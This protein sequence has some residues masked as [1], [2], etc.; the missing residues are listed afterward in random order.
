MQKS[1]LTDGNLVSL[2][3]DW[4]SKSYGVLD[5]ELTADRAEALKY[6][7]GDPFGNEVEGRSAVVSRDVLDV[8]ESALPQLLKVF[9]S[10]DEIVRFE[11]RGQEDE[12]AAAQETAV[13][14]YVALEKND[15]FAIFYTWFKDALLSKNGYVKV[16]Y[17][18]GKDVK[19]E[20]YQG[21]TDEQLA[22]LLR[23]D[24]V[25]VIEHS[26]T[27][28]EADLVM[29]QEAIAQ[30]Q[31][32]EQI[33]AIQMEPTK[34][35]HDVKIEITETL[36]KIAI[37]NVAPEDILVGHDTRS[38]SL[39]DATF[40]QHRALMSRSEIDEQGWDVP[41]N[42]E[43][44]T[45]S[46][47]WE[48][49]NARDIYNENGSLIDDQYLVKDT[50]IRVDGELLRVV[51]IGNEIVYRK[52]AEVI[53][54]AAI[55]PH[56]MPHRHVGMSYA[57]LTKD[58]QLIKSTLI[59]GELDAMYL[60]NQPRF[61]ISERVN[62]NDMLV[63]RPNGVVRVEGDPGS[64]IMPLVSP[65]PSP[66]SFNLVEYLDVAKE[67][68]TGITA[69]NQGLDANSLNKTA[70]GVSQIMQAAQQRLDLVARTFANTGV[71]E[72]FILVHRMI[73]THY[74][75]PETIK[76]RGQWV[77]VD[78]REWAERKNMSVVVGLG[79]GNRDQQLTHLNNMIALQ[80]QALQ[81][82]LPMVTP[83]NIFNTARQIAI[84]AG[85]KQP[86]L[87]VT[88]P[89]QVPPKPPQEPPQLT[90]KKMELQADAQKF[91]AETVVRQEEAERS[92]SVEMQKAQ[93]Q[94]EIDQRQ[95]EQNA[96]LEQQ[97]S[98]NDMQLER[99][100]MAMQAELK[101]YEIDKKIE[102]DLFIAQLNADTTI[103]IGATR[104][105]E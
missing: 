31:N 6:Y 55:T 90:I 21:L 104:W 14:N 24:R 34:F 97:R 93:Y 37:C 71:K 9:V 63:S 35:L 75:K 66:I 85:F 38:V 81:A 54:F 50:Y 80:M 27:I 32:P 78:P 29:R 43:R 7:N 77:T 91:Q 2:I 48:E 103:R 61:A 74:T 64:S 10:G 46:H 84:N 82:G 68:R 69:Y 5:S 28:D 58:I 13:V 25:T 44:Y 65:G 105:Q 60:A 15:G 36:D 95:A 98:Q 79:T 8:I 92:A 94:A 39:S 26:Q 83:E 1:D 52:P 56:I 11:P 76:L 22:I 99:E 19:I 30:A 87:F 102:A 49:E 53:P 3:E 67:R 51:V 59:R 45:D 40:V 88:D 47:S 42:V 96:F 12:E 16:W 72:L 18:E 23:N 89:K 57:D 70:S 20:S 101:R 86:E 17:E 33:A 4:E 62:L 73:R 41:E 100:K